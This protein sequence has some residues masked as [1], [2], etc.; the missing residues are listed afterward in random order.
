MSLIQKEVRKFTTPQHTGKV[1]FLNMNVSIAEILSDALKTEA[2]EKRIT[3]H[4][5]VFQQTEKIRLK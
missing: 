4:E 1:S 2:A 5:S 3:V